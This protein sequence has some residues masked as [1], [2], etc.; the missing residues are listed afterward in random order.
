MDLILVSS[1]F[2]KNVIENTVFDKRDGKGI[3]SY[4]ASKKS[5]DFT[6]D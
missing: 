4:Y 2:T 6:G 5:G 3:A 1:N